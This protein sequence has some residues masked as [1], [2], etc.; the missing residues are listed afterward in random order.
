MQHREIITSK[1][2]KTEGT[3]SQLE[4]LL[5]RG[6]DIQSFKKGLDQLK[7]LI[8][9]TKDYIQREPRTSNEL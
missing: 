4:S 7:D 3:I 2:E 9:D 6:G 5:S 1:L 8:Q